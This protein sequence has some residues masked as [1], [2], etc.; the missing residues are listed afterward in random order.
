MRL[1]RFLV[2]VGIVVA[3]IS[4][5]HS[6]L[7]YTVLGVAIWTVA[8][9]ASGMTSEIERF[10][11]LSLRRPRLYDPLHRTK[12]EIPGVGISGRKR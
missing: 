8:F 1:S 5:Y 11:R 10:I 6:R 2:L 4:A 12:R 3:S 9:M 7:S